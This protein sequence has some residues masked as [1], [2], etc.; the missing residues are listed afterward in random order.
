MAKI[1]G[2]N[3][4][5]EIQTAA[6]STMVAVSGQTNNV[7]LNF[8]TEE[9]ETTG[10][11]N[12]FTETLAN[13]VEDWTLSFNAFFDSG[14]AQI[15]ATLFGLIVTGSTTLNFG[16]AGSTACEVCM[17]PPANVQAPPAGSAGCAPK[18]A[19]TPCQ[20]CE[21]SDDKRGACAAICIPPKYACPPCWFHC[22]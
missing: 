22:L 6:A 11:G 9:V 16:P 10:F 14:A 18:C 15:D 19:R 21:N 2:R 1:L 12:S 20:F 13:G 4:S 7:T 17:H 5:L 8:T 3:A